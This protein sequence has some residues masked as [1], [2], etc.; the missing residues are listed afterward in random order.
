MIA[1]GSDAAV[2]DLLLERGADRAL[3]DKQGKT[4]L[5]LAANPD[6]R[7]RLSR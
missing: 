3:K 2:V 7:A 6:V 1:A 4:A 5:D